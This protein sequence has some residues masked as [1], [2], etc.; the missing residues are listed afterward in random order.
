VHDIANYLMDLM[1]DAE[2]RR[3]MGEA[4]RKRAVENYHYRIV[5]R[6]FTKTVAEKLGIS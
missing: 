6:Q 5:A 1:Q 2:L 4:G 3:R